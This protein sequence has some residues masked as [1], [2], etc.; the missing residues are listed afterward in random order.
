MNTPARPL[1]AR[2]RAFPAPRVYAIARKKQILRGLVSFKRGAVT[3]FT[4]SFDRSRLTAHVS[5][6]PAGAVEFR[7][8]GDE[9]AFRCSC[10]S[11][12]PGGNCHHVVCSLFAIKNLLNPGLFPLPAG[13]EA[14][15]GTLRERLQAGTLPPTAAEIPGQAAPGAGGRLPGRPAPTR[16]SSRRTS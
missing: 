10:A 15:R 6:D 13:A 7:V 11:W 14:R 5:G 8:E 1:F 4:W 2:L 12:E 3:D 9:L 16:S